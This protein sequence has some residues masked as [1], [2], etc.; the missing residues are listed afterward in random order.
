MFSVESTYV[1]SLRGVHWT[2]NHV[3]VGGWASGGQ[4]RVTSELTDGGQVRGTGER[5][6]DD[7]CVGEWGQGGQ[8]RG[9]P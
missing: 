8:V 7:R 2:A 3:R 6:E 9:K 4:M 1:R 5:H